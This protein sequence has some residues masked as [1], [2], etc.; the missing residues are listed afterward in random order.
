MQSIIP[1]ITLT[2]RIILKNKNTVSIKSFGERIYRITKNALMLN[3]IDDLNDKD[4]ERL[5]KV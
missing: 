3:V 4:R 5:K 2:M 1:T